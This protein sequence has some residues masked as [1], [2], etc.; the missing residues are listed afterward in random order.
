MCVCVWEGGRG[1]GGRSTLAEL[2]IE[3]FPKGL[4]FFSSH[5]ISNCL[6]KTMRHSFSCVCVAEPKFFLHLTESAFFARGWRR[7]GGLGC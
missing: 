6:N 7:G 4:Q 2:S 5:I 1:G 3:L